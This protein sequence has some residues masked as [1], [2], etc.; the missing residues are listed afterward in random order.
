MSNSKPK[1]VFVTDHTQVVKQ[2]REGLL[3]SPAGK[4]RRLYVKDRMDIDAIVEA[5]ALHGD[6]GDKQALHDAI[7]LAVLGPRSMVLIE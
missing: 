6:S 4:K 1:P 7:A 2:Y 3:A 5:V